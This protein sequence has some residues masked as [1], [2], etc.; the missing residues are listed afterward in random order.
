MHREVETFSDGTQLL[1]TWAGF[2]TARYRLWNLGSAVSQG[3][4]EI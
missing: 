2:D 1:S 3:C 4:G